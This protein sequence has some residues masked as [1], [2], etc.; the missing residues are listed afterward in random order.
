MLLTGFGLVLCV[1]CSGVLRRNA[2]AE[3]GEHA[4][5]AIIHFI[6]E[7]SEVVLLHHLKP[8]HELLKKNTV[9]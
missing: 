3:E 2:A 7:D 4:P 8:Q 5:H 6:Q 1:C 9:L